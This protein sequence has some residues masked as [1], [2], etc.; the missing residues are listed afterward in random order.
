MNLITKEKYY[1]CHVMLEQ[2]QAIA[3]KVS[4]FFAR[5]CLNSTNILDL[6]DN[7]TV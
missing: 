5:F 6:L 1:I 4:Y 2:M 3:L 7:G